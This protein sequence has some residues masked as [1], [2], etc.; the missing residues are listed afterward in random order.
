[1]ASLF[2]V[3]LAFLFHHGGES[4]ESIYIVASHVDPRSVTDFKGHLASMHYTTIPPG[5][6]NNI[7]SL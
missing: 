7:H 6:V 2:L 3:L 4:I 5:Q 1:M